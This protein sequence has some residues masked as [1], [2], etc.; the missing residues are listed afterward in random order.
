[1]TFPSSGRWI[2]SSP[3]VEQ[4]HL[5]DLLELEIQHRIIAVALQK[6]RPVSEKY[7]FDDYASS[8]NIGEVVEEIR[9]LSAKFDVEIP[10][11]YIIAFRSVL[12]PE[13][14]N[15][16]DLESL[17][18]F[19]KRSHAEAN[20]LGGLLKYWFGVPDGETGQNLATCWW[21][22]AEDAKIGGTGNAHR[23]SVSKTRQWYQ[24][25]HVE[26]YILELGAKSWKL[27]SRNS[28][29]QHEKNKHGGKADQ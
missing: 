22:S 20:Q 6:F 17:Y 1:M 15:P 11:I 10:S 9:G 13:K 19:D 26:E 7:A 5:L 25:W 4:E 12:N 8:F 23:E 14:R 29:P 21:R 27:R 18:D 28:T 2:I 16:V 3:Y 24:L